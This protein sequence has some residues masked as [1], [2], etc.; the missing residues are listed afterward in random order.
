M[1]SVVGGYVPLAIRDLRV[2]FKCQ[3][4]FSFLRRVC[5]QIAGADVHVLGREFAFLFE[6]LEEGLGVTVLP[7]GMT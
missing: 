7:L 1:V 3:P 6:G 4:C 2:R 5:V